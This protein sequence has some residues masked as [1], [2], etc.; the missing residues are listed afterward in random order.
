MLEELAILG[1][2]WRDVGNSSMMELF[3]SYQSTLLLDS[4]TSN[5]LFKLRC[6]CLL[7]T[8]G[9]GDGT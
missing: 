6:F 2:R 8:I 4:V 5:V 3:L 1:P 9:R 7:V